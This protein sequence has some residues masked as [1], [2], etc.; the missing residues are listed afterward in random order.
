MNR[1]KQSLLCTVAGFASIVDSL[2][3]EDRMI[4]GWGLDR[5]LGGLSM[6]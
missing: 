4:G 6:I 1:N 3:V 5:H 2:Y